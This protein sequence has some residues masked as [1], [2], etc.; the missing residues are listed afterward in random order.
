M[1]ATMN[2]LTAGSFQV[3]G[4]RAKSDLRDSTNQQGSQAGP[5]PTSIPNAFEELLQ[6]ELY[7]EAAA[8]EM[9]TGTIPDLRRICMLLN[10]TFGEQN[11]TQSALLSIPV[12]Q[13]LESLKQ[14]EIDS[15]KQNQKTSHVLVENDLLK[16]VLIH[17]R[18]GKISSI[19]GHPKGGC[20]FKVLQGSV[21]ELRYSTDASPKLL[22]TS[23]YHAGSMA[24]IDDRIGYHAVGNPNNTS[25]IS[26][27]VYTTGKTQV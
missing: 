20:V 21:E 16:V 3:N 23:T 1:K 5:I 18:P 11:R 4:Y 10:K 7:T 19:H 25:A 27:H 8:S 22:A 24:Y 15:F 6:H 9:A 13:E 2:E 17:W 12:L 14:D 26:L